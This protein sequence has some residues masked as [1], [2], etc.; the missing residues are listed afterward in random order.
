VDVLQASKKR[1]PVPCEGAV[2][3]LARQ[4]RSL[5]MPGSQ[6]QYT[7]AGAL[8]H[9]HGQ[10]KPWYVQATHD[11][12]SM[13]RH[14]RLRPM[15]AIGCLACSGYYLIRDREGL[16]CLH[17]CVSNVGEGDHSKQKQEIAYA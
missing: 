17:E 3:I 4:W 11:V 5:N 7:R 16:P 6:A 8:Q 12:T 2:S 15:A 10:S 1:I 14:K 13:E 9:W